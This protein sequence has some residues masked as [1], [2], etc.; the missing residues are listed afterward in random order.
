MGLAA[1]VLAARSLGSLLFEVKPV[2]APVYAGVAALVLA[3]TVLASW[4]PALRAT[5]VDPMTVL[6]EE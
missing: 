4:L 2:S 1:A 3:A 6:R 5:R